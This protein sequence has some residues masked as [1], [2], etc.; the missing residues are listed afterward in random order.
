MLLQLGLS[1]HIFAILQ[2]VSV[3]NGAQPGLNTAL[4]I[5]IAAAILLAIAGIILPLFFVF[6]GVVG[7]AALVVGLCSVIRPRIAAKKAPDGS[8]AK[9]IHP[10]ALTASILSLIGSILFI[11]GFF[12]VIAFIATALLILAAILGLV[13]LGDIKKNPTKYKGKWLARLGM[14]PFVSVVLFAIIFM[15]IIIASYSRGGQY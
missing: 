11:A 4:F 3:Q 2:S 13:A 8:D 15:I 6:A 7:V 5:L 14:L 10:L 9:V 1:T 12:S